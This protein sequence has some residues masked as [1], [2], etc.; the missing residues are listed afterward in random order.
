[1]GTY[2]MTWSLAFVCGPSLGMVLFAKSPLALW[3][4]CGV[5]GLVAAA[6]ILADGRQE[7]TASGQVQSDHKLQ[8]IRL[9]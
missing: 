3:V 4:L 7:P 8:V 1:M 9:E 2:G 5:L 6:I